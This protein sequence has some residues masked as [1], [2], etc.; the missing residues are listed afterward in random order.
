MGQ[1]FVNIGSPPLEMFE[2]LEKVRSHK[3]CI[4]T[5]VILA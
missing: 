3:V 4:E 5:L 2:I 1:Y